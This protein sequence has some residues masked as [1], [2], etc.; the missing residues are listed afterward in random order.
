MLEVSKDTDFSQMENGKY[1]L[2]EGKAYAIVQEYTTKP[3]ED[4]K[5]EAHRKYV[6]I[7]FVAQGEEK[8]GRG[9]LE[10]FEEISEYDEEKD[11]VFLAPKNGVKEECFKLIAG[12]FAIFTRKMFTCLV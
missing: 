6:D 7:Q 8:L 9:A 12:E 11:I 5:Y 3:E 4:G 2:I 1:D 10:D